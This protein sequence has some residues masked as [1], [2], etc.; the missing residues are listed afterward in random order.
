MLSLLCCGSAIV[1]GLTD[2][3][4]PGWPLSHDVPVW[5]MDSTSGRNVVLVSDIVEQYTKLAASLSVATPL[6]TE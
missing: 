3:R 5:V 6:K 4:P 2:R 1:A